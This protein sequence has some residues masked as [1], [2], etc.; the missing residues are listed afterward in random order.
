MRKWLIV[1]L[2][3][4]WLGWELFAA[5]DGSSATWTLTQII[6]EYVPNEVAMAAVAVLI[7]WLPVHF[8]RKSTEGGANM[9]KYSKAIVAALVAGLGT[10]GTALADDAV[11]S[12][13]W[14]A[15]AGATLGALGVVWSV[16]NRPAPAE[17]AV[18]V[19]SGRAPY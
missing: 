12:L 15:I 13:E 14:V 4:A 5:N 17:G 6:L 10:L 2:S 3:A 9:G 18:Q 19:Q 16:P 1:I 8:R 7:A 11:T